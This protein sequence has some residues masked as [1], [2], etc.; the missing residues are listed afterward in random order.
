MAADASVGLGHRDYA[1]LCSAKLLLPAQT[2]RIEGR[3]WP[4]GGLWLVMRILG[5]G[6]CAVPSIAAAHGYR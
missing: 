2:R 4:G 5:M 1:L 6:T 3:A